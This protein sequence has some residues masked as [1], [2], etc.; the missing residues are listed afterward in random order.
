MHTYLAGEWSNDVL[1]PRP[2]DI[3][4]S[5]LP[6]VAL[7]LAAVLAYAVVSISRLVG[8]RNGWAWALGSFFFAPVVIIWLF[9]VKNHL[10]RRGSEMTR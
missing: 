4:W 3:V 7:V 8:I 10:A 9:V 1:M 2:Y 5:I 6:I